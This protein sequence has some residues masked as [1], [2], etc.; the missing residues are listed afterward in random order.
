MATAENLDKLIINKVESQDVYDY[1][2]SHGLIN[3][4][5]LYLVQGASD[6]HIVIMSAT[7]P[8]SLG[9]GDDWDKIL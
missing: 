5:E 9:S 4:D 1:M 3:S 8:T 2:V 6:A 7:Q